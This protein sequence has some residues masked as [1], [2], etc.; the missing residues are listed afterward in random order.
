MDLDSASASTVNFGH[1]VQRRET[2]DCL[3]GWRY[4]QH[5]CFGELALDYACGCTNV[6]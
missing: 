4:S 1:P 6:G 5:F 3:L 2:K